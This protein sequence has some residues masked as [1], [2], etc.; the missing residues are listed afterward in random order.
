MRTILTSDQMASADAYTIAT[1]GVPGVDLMERAAQ[2]CA[3]AIAEMVTPLQTIAIIAG[4]GNNGGDGLAIARILTER[5]FRAKLFLATPDKPFR[6]D[7]AHHFERMRAAGVPVAPIDERSLS[8]EPYGLIVDALFGT[9]LDRPLGGA[10]RDLVMRMNAAPIPIFAVDLPSG[11]SGNSGRLLGE[12]VRATRTVTF[13]YL[14]I[15]HAVSPACTFCGH[16]TVADIGIRRPP[17]EVYRHHLLEA[18]DYRRPARSAV[19]HKGSFGTLGIIGGFSGMEGAAN[20]AAVAALRFGVGKVRV[21]TNNRNR[22]HHDSVMVENIAHYQPQYNALV[23]GPGLSRSDEAYAHIRRLNLERERVVWD[24]DAIHYLKRHQPSCLGGEWVMTPHPGEAAELLDCLAREVQQD[25]LAAIHKL[26]ELFPGGWIL[27]K[28][29]RTLIRAPE[30]DVTVCGP[31]GPALAV[32]GSGDVLSGMIGA[33][34][35]QGLS[36][37]D[38]VLLACL[39]HALAGDHWSA[40]HPDYSMLAEDIIHDLTRRIGS[41]HAVSH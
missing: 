33:L 36:I 40:D 3:T 35:A 14:K 38:S 16:V 22:Y 5:G 13:Q 2:A 28:G 18:D 26:A 7:A 10:I 11:L 9:G 27:L 29:F 1:L 31:G 34:L 15:A 30:G 8:A 41:H 23:I 25:R 20:L 17:G 4:S 12:T 24:A 19:T 39:R 21:Y 37:K 32:A 6:G